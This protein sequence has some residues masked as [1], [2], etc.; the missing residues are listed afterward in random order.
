MNYN[1]CMIYCIRDDWLHK[2]PKDP[3]DNFNEILRNR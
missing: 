1:K 3:D 2:T